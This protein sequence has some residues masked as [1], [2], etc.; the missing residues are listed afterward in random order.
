MI[1]NQQFTYQLNRVRIIKMIRI[2]CLIVAIPTRSKSVMALVTSLI[3]QSKSLEKQKVLNIFVAINDKKLLC[4]TL[5][6]M[7]GELLPKENVIIC[8]SLP[9]PEARN[10]LVNLLIDKVAPDWLLF[11]DDDVQ[12][13]RQ[14]SHLLF[15]IVQKYPQVNL[16]CAPQLT[17]PNKDTFH[18]D[19]DFLLTHPLVVFFFTSRYGKEGIWGAFNL[20]NQDHRLTLCN[21]LIK[22]KDFSSFPNTIPYGEEIWLLKK[23]KKNASN[24][25][26]VKDER[27]SLYHQRKPSLATFLRQMIRSGYG[28]GL[29]SQFGL[30]QLDYIILMLIVIFYTLILFFPKIVLI[31]L[32]VH[33]LLIFLHFALK[34]NHIRFRIFFLPSLMVFAYSIGV[35]IGITHSLLRMDINELRPKK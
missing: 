12:I 32:G 6:E 17:L 13:P 23:V 21:L 4:E 10:L 26:I 33:G 22:F 29:S 31:C 28:R 27:L 11:L 24:F 2:A 35:V 9:A 15:E 19:Q 18:Q 7:L 25:I 1:I 20:T 30:I 8:P 3:E 16:I 5:F 14:F 34:K